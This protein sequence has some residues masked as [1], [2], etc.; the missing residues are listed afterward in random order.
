MD[1]KVIEKD[2]NGYLNEKG[3]HLFQVKYYKKDETLEVLLDDKLGMEELE[4]ISADLSAYMDK[5]DEE[6]EANYILDVSTVGVERPIRNEEELVKA[7][8]SYIYV[9]T[10]ERD[11]NGTFKGYE[12]GVMT[13]TVKDK[14]RTKDVTV[15]YTSAKKVRYA[16]E[17]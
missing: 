2:L 12:N 14:T 11:Y 7:I 4:A 8:G 3:L 17:F 13:L 9:K 16:V 15:E 5:Y 1:L 6:F 10:K